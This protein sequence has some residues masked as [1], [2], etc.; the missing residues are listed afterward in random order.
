MLLIRP[1]L[2]A[3]EWSNAI[4]V[5]VLVNFLATYLMAQARPGPSFTRTIMEFLGVLG[6]LGKAAMFIA[7]ASNN[8]SDLVELFFDQ[9]RELGRSVPDLTS[10]T[11]A[12]HSEPRPIAGLSFPPPGYAYATV[13]GI[14]LLPAVLSRHRRL[15]RCGEVLGD[16]GLVIDLLGTLVALYLQPPSTGITSVC[17]SSLIP[18][19]TLVL[20]QLAQIPALVSR[21]LYPSH[22]ARALLLPLTCI[23]TLILFSIPPSSTQEREDRHLG[24]APLPHAFTILDLLPDPIEWVCK[25]VLLVALVLRAPFHCAQ[26]IE[27]IE[28]RHQPGRTKAG[29]PSTPLKFVRLL[30]LGLSTALAAWCVSD[31]SWLATILGAITSLPAMLLAPL[32][33]WP[34]VQSCGCIHGLLVI[35][36]FF[37][38]VG[39]CTTSLC[40]NCFLW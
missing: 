6:E 19:T 28:Q 23:S 18:M 38:A 17:L 7:L 35:L 37:G 22:A 36:A 30:E 39:L 2:G 31:V 26:A 21:M 5:V 25:V 10:T 29:A 4:L 34:T 16:I 20:S 11:Q 13:L 32:L 14:L 15:V 24:P 12:L 3:E 9:H 1:G 33:A 27:W 40:P 8:I